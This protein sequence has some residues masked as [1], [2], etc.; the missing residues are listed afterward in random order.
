MLPSNVVIDLTTAFTTQ[1]RSRL[2]VD[3]I[4]GNRGHPALPQRHGRAEYRVLEL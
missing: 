4:T 2:P 3:P 1:E